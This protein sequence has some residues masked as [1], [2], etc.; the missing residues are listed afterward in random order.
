MLTR[1]EVIE[2]KLPERILSVIGIEKRGLLFSFPLGQEANLSDH[3]FGVD[4]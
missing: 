1:L 2:L 4:V 3:R